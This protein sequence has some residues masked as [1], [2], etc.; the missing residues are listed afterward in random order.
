MTNFLWIHMTVSYTMVLYLFILHMSWFVEEKEYI[1]M[2]EQRGNSVARGSSS[3]PRGRKDWAK[4]TEGIWQHSRGFWTPPHPR[5]CFSHYCSL[6]LGTMPHA[7][8]C[9]SSSTLS[10]PRSVERH[11]IEK[12]NVLMVFR[13]VFSWM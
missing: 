12:V 5:C 13:V 11:S 10:P 2:E 9:Y 4:T 3:N 8:L 7:L 6:E 1:S